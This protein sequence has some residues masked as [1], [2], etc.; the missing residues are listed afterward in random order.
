MIKW[1][2][3]VPRNQEIARLRH[4]DQA[5]RLYVSGVCSTARAQELCHLHVPIVL[6]FGSL[7]LPEPS[8]PVQACTVIPRLTSEPANEFFG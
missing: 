4:T 7:S 8:G 2:Q 1:F 3:H 6:K 5:C